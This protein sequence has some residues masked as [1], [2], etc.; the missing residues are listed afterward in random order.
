MIDGV[1][2]QLRWGAGQFGRLVQSV[3][4]PIQDSERDIETAAHGI[5][6]EA[7]LLPELVAQLGQLNANLVGL[8][9]V[10]RP[11]TAVENEIGKAEKHISHL[12]HHSEPES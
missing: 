11:I 6:G 1:R 9:S 2:N 4:Q 10:L 12:F 8:V 3:T 7:E 5:R